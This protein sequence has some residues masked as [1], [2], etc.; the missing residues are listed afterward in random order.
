LATISVVKI[1]FLYTYNT[2]V[3]LGLATRNG[4]DGPGFEILVRAGISSPI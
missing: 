2:F 1:L 4:L 3:W